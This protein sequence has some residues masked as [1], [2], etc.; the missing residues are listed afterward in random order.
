MKNIKKYFTLKDIENI[1]IADGDLVNKYNAKYY[2][3]DLKKKFRFTKIEN[4]SD[5]PLHLAAKFNRKNFFSFLIEDM[6]LS[7]EL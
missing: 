4:S 1:N 5:S 7:K 6:K 2:S 3:K